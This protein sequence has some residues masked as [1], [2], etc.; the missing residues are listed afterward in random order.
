MT[1]DSLDIITRITVELFKE[2]VPKQK[3]GTGVIYSNKLLSGQVYILTAKHCLSG[4]CEG[5]KISLR[6]FSTKNGAYEYVT[7][8][9]QTIIRHPSED[10]GIIILI[11]V[12]LQ[13]RAII[14][15]RFCNR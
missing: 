1:V 5:E 11:S 13:K 6:F 9:N 15:L 14:Y 2:G 3:L 12:S 7:P 4:I 8:S 10:A